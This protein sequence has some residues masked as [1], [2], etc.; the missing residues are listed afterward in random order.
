MLIQSRAYHCQNLVGK[1][2]SVYRN[3][4]VS[5]PIE[6]Y[7]ELLDLQI[8]FFPNT[9]WEC[10]FGIDP[11]KFSENDRARQHC[12]WCPRTLKDFELGC[13]QPNVCSQMKALMY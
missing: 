1:D 13:S 12:H 7:A 2:I 3:N 8:E 4:L 11:K 9:S 5:L 6:K 10:N